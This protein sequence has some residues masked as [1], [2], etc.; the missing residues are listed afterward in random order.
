MKVFSTSMVRHIISFTAEYSITV[1]PFGYFEH[2][3]N[4]KLNTLLVMGD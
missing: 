3:L 4:Y 1:L 2:V